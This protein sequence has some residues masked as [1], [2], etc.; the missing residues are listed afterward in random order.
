MYHTEALLRLIFTDFFLK[1][2]NQDLYSIWGTLTFVLMGA[3]LRN[4]LT[5]IGVRH[6]T[7]RIIL[8]YKTD[9]N[10]LKSF[11]VIVE[12]VIKN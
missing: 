11:F 6:P 8:I 4:R 3:E 7:T 9:E 5:A 12:T 10:S 1:V 2:D